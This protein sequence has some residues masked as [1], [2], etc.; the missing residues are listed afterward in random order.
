MKRRASGNGLH[1][2]ANTLNS[3]AF[4]VNFI[5]RQRETKEGKSGYT[6][7]RNLHVKIE[8]FGVRENISFLEWAVRLE[9]D[10]LSNESGHVGRGRMD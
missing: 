7:V 8:W 10:E 4:A 5:S 2:P 9:L 3:F 1:K 6:H